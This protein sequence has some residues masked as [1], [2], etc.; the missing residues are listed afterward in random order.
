MV[1][2][3]PLIDFLKGY[4][5]FTILVYHS[6]LSLE[7]NS[8][9]EKAIMFGGT[10]VHLFIFIS[11]FGLYA[12]YLRKPIDFRT[13]IRKRLSNIYIP[14]IIV[15]TF[16]AGVS[17]IIPF[18]NYDLYTFAGHAFLYKMFDNNID[19]TYG[20]Q[21]WFI[22]TIIQLYL[23]FYILVKVKSMTKSSLFIF[24]GIA[25]SLLWSVLVF[26]LHKGEYRVWNSF[27]LQYLWEFM[28]GMSVA[29]LYSRDVLRNTIKN[30]AYLI[31]GSVL[32]GINGLLVLR[33]GTA[34]KLFNDVPAFLGYT[35]LAIF[36]FKLNL[37]PVNKFFIFTGKISYSLYLIHV[38]IIAITYY[39]FEIIG[40]V[41][42]LVILLPIFIL[43]YLLSYYYNLMVGRILS[44]WRF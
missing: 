1:K 8:Y 14:Y 3:I 2:K 44:K 23:T 7:L 16:L 11:G 15:I 32:I 41:H 35:S 43:T 18:Y 34:G 38:F 20:G 21:F 42:S 10:G 17:F 5:I 4:S 33:G 6:L 19:E 26:C 24:A 28:L 40:L 36:I 29:E 22:S 27:F 31:F 9:L 37:R 12:S 25:I 13:F 30:Y 39:L